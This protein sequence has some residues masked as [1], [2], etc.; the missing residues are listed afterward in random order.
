MKSS[1]F[2]RKPKSE[3]FQHEKPAIRKNKFN[4]GI[5]IYASIVIILLFFIV[6]FLINE[7]LFVSAEGQVLYKKLDVQLPADV[8][9]LEIY[10]SEGNKIN[11]GDTLFGYMWSEA[12]NPFKRNTSNFADTQ[13]D[14][15][16]RGWIQKESNR[17]MKDIEQLRIDN[18]KNRDLLEMYQNRMKKVEEGVY[19]NVYTMDQ[20]DQI[21]EKIRRLKANIRSKYSEIRYLRKYID[22]LNEKKGQKQAINSLLSSQQYRFNRDTIEKYA[23]FYQAPIGGALTHVFK[24]N[25]EVAASSEK[26]MAIHQKN[27]IIIRAY[28]N[29][30]DLEYVN[31]GDHVNIQFPDGSESVGKLERFYRSTYELPK[32]F[33]KKNEPTDRRIAADIKPLKKEK[34]GDWKTYYKMSV[35]I[36]KQVY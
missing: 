5:V 34:F 15:I 4:W 14:K 10:E 13:S 26:I 12:F 16:D 32:E 18:Q 21:K 25:F 22:Q 8:Q 20:L 35:K 17:V 6:K 3:E 2:S 19:L 31:K 30:E 33:Q 11:A 29:Q 7:V 1:Q 27:E 28:F 23:E 36:T 9:L 24:D